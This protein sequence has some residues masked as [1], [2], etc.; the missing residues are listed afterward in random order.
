MHW[1]EV[2]KHICKDLYW[3]VIALIALFMLLMAARAV[4]FKA[5]PLDPPQ[6]LRIME[7][8]PFYQE[9]GL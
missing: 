5:Y 4:Y 2:L 6:G 8:T 3:T 7:G 1:Y 9:T